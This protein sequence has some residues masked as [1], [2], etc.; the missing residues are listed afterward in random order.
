MEIS[1]YIIQ[2]LTLLT[3]SIT[4]GIAWNLIGYANVFMKAL[5]SEKPKFKFAK[6]KRSLLTGIFVGFAVF[7]YAE[8][9]GSDQLV[10]TTFQQ[11]LVAVNGMFLT[12]AFIERVLLSKRN[13]LKA[14]A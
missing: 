10:V 1:P 4:A 2:V 5:K 14:D 11:F 6:M 8:F 7:I 12:V 3:V 13:P 9:T